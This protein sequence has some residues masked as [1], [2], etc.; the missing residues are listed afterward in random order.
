MI[1]LK[2]TLERLQ[3][4]PCEG[5]KQE[6]ARAEME[7]AAL[8]EF[9][10]KCHQSGNTQ[11]HV[12]QSLQE[13]H[14]MFFIRDLA[15]HQWAQD[16]TAETYSQSLPTSHCIMDAS[17]DQAQPSGSEEETHP[18]FSKDTVYHAGI[19]SLAVNDVK[20]CDPGNYQKFFQKNPLIRGHDFQQ[21]SVSKSKNDRYLIA[22]QG[23]STVYIAFQS[24]PC[25]Q[26][27]PKLF[28]SFSEGKPGVVDVF[29]WQLRT[30]FI[31]QG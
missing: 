15:I 19:C 27:W 10:V 25:I 9:V 14:K 4:I 3:A 22:R 8:Q 16:L 12:E 30:T 6:E 18:L 23:E 26:Q 31:L 13:L 24:E 29:I 28:R 5:D 21:V 17:E 11:K 1:R 2:V 7:K 20:E